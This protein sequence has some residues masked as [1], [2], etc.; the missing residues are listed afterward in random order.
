MENDFRGLEDL[1]K[2]VVQES[3]C[4]FSLCFSLCYLIF[5]REIQMPNITDH[6]TAYYDQSAGYF[7]R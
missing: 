2:N 4:P 5:K 1:I 6:C 7:R 3:D